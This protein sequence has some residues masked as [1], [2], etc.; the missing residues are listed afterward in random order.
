M[1]PGPQ[2]VGAPNFEMKTSPILDE[3]EEFDVLSQEL[4][5]F[6]SCHFNDVLYQSG[7]YVCSGS[8]AL[9]CCE[10]GLWVRKGGCDPD[11]P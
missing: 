10:K 2:L 3:D 11:N 5:E 6:P 9:L 8:G 4:E 7:T 1:K